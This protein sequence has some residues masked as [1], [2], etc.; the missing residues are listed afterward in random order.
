MNVIFPLINLSFLVWQT[1]LLSVLS[2]INYVH[3]SG[4]EAAAQVSLG[5]L[6]SQAIDTVF[7]LLGSEDQR[8][9]DAAAEAVAKWDS[10]DVPHLN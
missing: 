8:V 10:Q 4:T 9:R 7:A 5:A 3:I 1:E 6:E 2:S